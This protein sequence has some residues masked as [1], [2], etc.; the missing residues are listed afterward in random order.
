VPRPVLQRVV[1]GLD[2]PV[3]PRGNGATMPCEARDSR[4]GS[5]S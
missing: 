1:P 3:D 4:M 5:E 2:P